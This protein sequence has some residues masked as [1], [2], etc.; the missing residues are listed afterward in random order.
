MKKMPKVIDVLISKLVEDPDNPNKMTDEEFKALVK[1]IQTVGFLQ[2]I[3]IQ[4]LEDSDGEYKIVDG[5]HRARAAQ[6]AGLSKVLAVVWDGTEEMRQALAIGMNKLR[7]A[8]NLGEVARI[9][10]ELS[11]KGWGVDDLTITG[12]SDEEITDLLK[13]AQ[14]TDADEVLEGAAAGLDQEPASDEGDGE[15]AYAL[16]LTFK[17][18]DDLRRVR[19]ALKKAAGKG[20]ELGDGMLVLLEGTE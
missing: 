11:A 5:H 10:Q 6:A 7:G 9:M 15:R 14:P 20:G 3:L 18:P 17:T 1:N 13:S 8:L 16:E 19:K 12:Y 2:P 4:A